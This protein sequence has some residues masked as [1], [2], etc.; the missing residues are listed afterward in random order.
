[1]PVQAIWYGERGVL[2]SLVGHIVRNN[3]IE[4]VQAVLGSIS[5][6]NEGDHDWV[7]H[8]KYVD[9]LVEIGLSEFG[10]PDLVI[11]CRTRNHGTHLV[12]VE[13]KRGRYISAAASN[14][15][16]MR[17]RAYN[18]SINGQLSLRYR[19]SRAIQEGCHNGQIQEPMGLYLAYA[20]A[21]IADASKAPRKLKNGWIL[22]TLDQIANGT[23]IISEHCH[24]V[25]LTSD[26]RPF[27]EEPLVA[28]DVLPVL[29]DEHGATTWEQTRPRLGWLGYN[30]LQQ[31]LD[32]P[33]EH[34]FVRALRSIGIGAAPAIEDVAGN[35]EPFT[36]NRAPI[37]EFS[38]ATQERFRELLEMARQLLGHQSVE[39]RAGS[40]SVVLGGIVRAKLI[41]FVSTNQ[42][43]RIWFGVT[44]DYRDVADLVPP[45]QEVR[46]NR[47][48]FYG[49]VLPQ[50]QMVD[51][52]QSIL[53]AIIE[54]WRASLTG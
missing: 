18:S 45:V 35:F 22:R 46:I 16:G 27:W 41:P 34:E 48:S 33:G 25:A 30:Q 28:E 50:A 54:Q 8:I 42:A 21:E 5:W 4:D 19:F 10:N 52:L 51:H 37:G 23:R 11:A 13:A 2:N 6:N 39:S 12:F 26:V 36:L 47:R 1:M 49:M 43:E 24:F 3:N 53:S 31:A 38:E 15:V 40:G 17:D 14:R 20:E 32:L 9:F 7:N 44:E 29:L